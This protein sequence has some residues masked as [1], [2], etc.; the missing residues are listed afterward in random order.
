MN[1]NLIILTFGRL[2]QMLIMFFTYRVLSSLLSVSE[3]GIYYFLLSISAAFGLIYANPIGMY[4]N[5]MMHGWLEHGVLHRNLKTVSLCFLVGSFLTIPFL[6]FFRQKISLDDQSFTFLISVLVFYIFSATLNGTIVP[7]L[8]LLG[9]TN[10]F[11]VWTFL[12]SGLGLLLS[13]LIVTYVSPGPLNWLVGQGLSFFL[14]G[15]IAM[16]ILFI[17]TQEKSGLKTEVKNAESRIRK[18]SSFAFPIVITNVAVWSLGHSFRFFYKENVDLNILG[19]LAFG[20]GLATSLSVAVE[21]LLQQIYLPEFYKELNDPLKDNGKVWNALLNKLLSP[22][23]YLMMFMI[24]LSPFIMNILADVKFKNAF[25]YLALGALVEFFRMCGNIFSMATHSEMKTNK[26][27]G[28]YLLGGVITILGVWV[29][30]QKPEYV[31]L[32]PFCLMAGYL[33]ALLYLRINVGKII[34]IK[35]RYSSLFKSGAISLIFL[36]GLLWSRFSENI[37]S[38]ILVLGVYGALFSFLM[39]R[40]YLKQKE[41]ESLCKK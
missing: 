9:F 4:T 10:Q 34:E 12:T 14:C 17:K 7:G 2:S 19:E 21:Y 33:A 8:N 30:C 20:L 3:V 40:D 16:V 28:P 13:Y 24:G 27:I 26:A 29:I 36:T 38:S 6:F 39:Y 15:I 41:D 11:V 23:L 25:Q 31:Y 37:F 18:V 22:Y 32:T 1:R 35:I 5:R